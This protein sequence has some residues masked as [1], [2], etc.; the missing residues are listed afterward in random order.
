MGQ[1]WENYREVQSEP[2]D[3]S[4]SK[5]H[6]TTEFAAMQANNFPNV[7]SILSFLLLVTEGMLTDTE[8]FWIYAYKYVVE[9]ITT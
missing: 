1:G 7:S 3:N 4:F 2:L 8:K 5:V 6:L 9:V